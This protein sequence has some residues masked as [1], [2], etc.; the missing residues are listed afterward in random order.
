MLCVDVYEVCELTGEGIEQIRTREFARQIEM[1]MKL[2]H[3]NKK[4]GSSGQ[5]QDASPTITL[6]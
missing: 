1:K 4:Y 5:L 3:D 2:W 6:S